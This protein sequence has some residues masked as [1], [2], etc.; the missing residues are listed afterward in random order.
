[1]SSQ[2]LNCIE[3]STSTTLPSLAFVGHLTTTLLLSFRNNIEK[4]L[5]QNEITISVL[6]DYSIW[7]HQSQNL[8][9]L[10]SLKFSNRTIKIIVSYLTNLHQYMQIHDQT[11]PKFL[12]HFGVPK[13]SI[14][15]P[16]LFN[17]YIAELPMTSYKK[18]INYRKTPRRYRSG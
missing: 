5:N 1:M 7:H 4:A 6:I 9:N 17:L 18:Y 8:E 3:K 12:V 2:P 11:S 13:G 10:V 16:I 15:G 14:L